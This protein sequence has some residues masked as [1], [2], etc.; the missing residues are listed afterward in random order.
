MGHAVVLGANL[1]ISRTVAEPPNQV[2]DF[3][4][5]AR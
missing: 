1:T 2:S 4:G 5:V 3:G